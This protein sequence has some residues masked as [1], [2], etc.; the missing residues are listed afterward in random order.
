MTLQGG[1]AGDAASLGGD[2][3]L[4]IDVIAIWRGESLVFELIATA[5]SR[6]RDG[7]LCKA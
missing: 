3:T 1:P 6:E 4:Q 2:R 7:V 5:Q